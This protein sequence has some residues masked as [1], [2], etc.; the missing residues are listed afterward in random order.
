MHV[1]TAKLH[2]KLSHTVNS[3]L[4]SRRFFK[5]WSRF[6]DYTS[7]DAVKE[8][9]NSFILSTPGP[10]PGHGPGHQRPENS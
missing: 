3:M 2:I 8:S 4:L 5:S 1:D 7:P 10:G 6:R 9:T